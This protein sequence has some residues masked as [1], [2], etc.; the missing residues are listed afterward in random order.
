M[1]PSKMCVSKMLEVPKTR[2]GKWLNMPATV[3]NHPDSW[4]A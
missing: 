1:F 3:L 4:K 2:G